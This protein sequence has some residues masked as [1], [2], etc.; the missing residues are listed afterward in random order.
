MLEMV[1]RM[2]WR[3]DFRG[4]SRLV[5][6]FPA[7]GRHVFRLP[8]GLMELDLDDS[9]QRQMAF[10]S[11]ERTEAR[12]ARRLISQGMT[13]LDIGA[14]VG[15]YS[16]LMAHEVGPSGNVIAVEPVPANVAV[17]T[18]NLERN[19][20]ARVS[21]LEAAASDTA[22]R[23]RLSVQ[24]ERSGWGS[25]EIEREG[26]HIDVPAVRM[27]EYLL[28][29]RIQQVGFIKIDVEGHELSVLR[30]LGEYLAPSEGP[31]LMVERLAGRNDTWEEIL[32]FL[33]GLGYQPIYLRGRAGLPRH[34]VFFR[35]ETHP[36]VV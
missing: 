3:I 20:L 27:D 12:I 15:F 16:L 35:K 23:A 29:R 19:G 18:R 21:V 6:A 34:N 7:H 31:M 11:F 14:H 5:R 26:G 30:G 9:G 22:R 2:M 25:L 17:L 10:G 33:G 13:T 32:A 4:K 28:E 8:W 1:A 24:P 36:P